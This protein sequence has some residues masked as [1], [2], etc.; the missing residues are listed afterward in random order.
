MACDGYGESL[1]FRSD[2]HD[3]F[4]LPHGIVTDFEDD[5][6]GAFVAA[7]PDREGG[8]FSE[9]DVDLGVHAFAIVES[10]RSVF[11]GLD[12]EGVNSLLSRRFVDDL[13]DALV[14]EGDIEVEDSFECLNE[15][16]W[17]DFYCGRLRRSNIVFPV[18]GG[19][20]PTKGLASQE[21]V[22]EAW[23]EK[24]VDDTVDRR[25]RELTKVGVVTCDREARGLRC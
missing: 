16:A 21:V 12:F 15:F 5:R 22:L 24:P 10:I 1:P 20:L 8:R 18:V 2:R 19:G 25:L 9:S 17:A 13:D 14:F 11:C 23:I 6:V 3:F 7:H 4:C